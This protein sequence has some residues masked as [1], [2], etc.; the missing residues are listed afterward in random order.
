MLS[1]LKLPDASYNGHCPRERGDESAV[2]SF[3]NDNVD[4][5]AENIY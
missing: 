3:W 5:S 2:W 1:F 4:N